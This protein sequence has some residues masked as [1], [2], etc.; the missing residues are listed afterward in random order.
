M[1]TDTNKHN[2]HSIARKISF[3]ITGFVIALIVG[4]LFVIGA[5]TILTSVMSL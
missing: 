3:T 2:P 4:P 1:R 5:Y